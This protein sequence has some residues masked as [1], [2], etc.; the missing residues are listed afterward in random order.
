VTREA[1]TQTIPE[2]TSSGSRWQPWLAVVAA[3]A[4]LVLLLAVRRRRCEHCGK[5]VT[6]QEGILVDEDE[7]YDCADNPNGDHHQLK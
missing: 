7:N 4:S 5:R 1:L 6:D 2:T 3:A